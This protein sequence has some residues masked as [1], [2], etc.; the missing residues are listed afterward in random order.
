[1]IGAVNLL[2]T[3][4]I[5]LDKQNII[6]TFIRIP[7]S[8]FFPILFLVRF[9]HLGQSNI[10]VS[11]IIW[12]CCSAVIFDS[13]FIS[14]YELKNNY[15]NYIKLTGHSYY[16]FRIIANAILFFMNAILYS[17]LII[18]LILL[19]AIKV[20]QLA[21]EPL[22][23]IALSVLVSANFINSLQIRFKEKQFFNVFNSL[24]DILFI[25]SGVM[26][27][28]TFFGNNAT[29]LY[30]I[31]TALPFSLLNGETNISWMESIL[32][33]AS[34]LLLIF[35]TNQNFKVENG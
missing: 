27:S 1:M 4:K 20:T 29:I 18:I 31:P 10:V 33:I 19:G 13:Y 23:L 34:I 7:F 24:V 28:V 12:T 25:V 32:F 3:K 11:V 6:Q 22:L 16:F 8:L 17:V 14:D 5:L 26:F 21:T 15:A 35:I 9:L 2:L 30:L